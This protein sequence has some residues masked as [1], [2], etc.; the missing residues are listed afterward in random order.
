VFYNFPR[1]ASYWT[2]T[3]SFTDGRDTSVW[4]GEF[5]YGGLARSTLDT[6][7][8]NHGVR[9]VRGGDDFDALE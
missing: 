6:F 7:L 5:N 8:D 3:V 9:L 4:R 2:S 1:L